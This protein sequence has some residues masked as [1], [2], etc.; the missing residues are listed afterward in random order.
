MWQELLWV[1]DKDGRFSIRLNLIQDDI[2]FS[3]RGSYFMNEENGLADG[4]RSMLER[5]FKSKE[6]QGLRAPNGQWNIWQVKRYLRAVNHFLG[7]KLVAYHVFNGQPARGSELTAMRFRNGAL[8]DRNQVVLDGV[9]MTV[10]RY[11]KSMS[12]WDSPKV[13]P[14]FLP[15]R[16]GQITTI[17]LA[18]VQPFAEYLQV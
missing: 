2:T 10:I 17:Y 9:M 5:A 16:L 11:Y 8:Q 15:A 14:R 3:R 6:G 7:K 1:P 4:L 12:Q 13:I 18:Y